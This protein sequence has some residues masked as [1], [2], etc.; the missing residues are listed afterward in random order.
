MIEVQNVVKKFDGFAALNG[1]TMTVPTGAVYGLVGPNGAG[2]S[3]ILRHI[4]GIYQQD[5]GEVLVD[6]QQVYENPAIKARIASIP[7]ELYYFLSASTKDM[8]RFY[9]GFYPRFDQKRY[10]ALKDIFSTV[11]QTHP[12]RRLSKGMQKQS[13][14]WLALCCRP[15]YLVLDEP[16]DGLDP[17]MRRQVWG[18]LMSDVAE[19]GTT[20]LVSSHNLRELE[21]VCDH[22]GILSKG[23]VLVERSLSEL[24]GNT[25]KVQVVFQ[26][27]ELPKFPEDMQIL[28]TSQT[29]RLTTMIVRGTNEEVINR[30]SVYTPLLLE[31]LPLSLEE[32]FIYELGGEDYAV[33]EIVV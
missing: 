26:E 28:H 14:F 9:K 7:D 32:I 22:V 27:K 18:L 1:L 21:D 33:R 16:V 5:E 2:K 17:V 13:A 11:K 15:D 6:G 4:T 25:V 10:E 8:M 29:G 12:I 30:L 3:T 24:Q 19:H 31:A 23:K 20:V